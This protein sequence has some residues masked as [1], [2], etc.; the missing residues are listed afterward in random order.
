MKTLISKIFAE[1][2]R[3]PLECRAYED[4][5]SALR[6]IETEDFAYAHSTNAV[7]RSHILKAL[8][9]TAE[10]Q[11]FF[12]LYKRRLHRLSAQHLKVCLLLRQ[13]L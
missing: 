3:Q 11:S 12:D 5:F 4:L 9:T 8:K 1:V 7:M 6:E 2:K 13:T 10:V